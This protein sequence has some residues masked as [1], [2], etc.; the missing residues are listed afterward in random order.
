[1]ETSSQ[2]LSPAMSPIPRAASQGFSFPLPDL[3]EFPPDIVPNICNIEIP[4]DQRFPMSDYSELPPFSQL[5]QDAF[6]DPSHMRKYRLM[7]PGGIDKQAQL[8]CKYRILLEKRLADLTETV[9]E[10]FKENQ[11][12]YVIFEERYNAKM[13]LLK[14]RCW[15]DLL[16][17]MIQ[18]FDD[19]ASECDDWNSSQEAC[20]EVSQAMLDLHEAANKILDEGTEPVLKFSDFHKTFPPCFIQ[21]FENSIYWN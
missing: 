7:H 9:I 4:L 6:K 20:E 18:D 17:Q 13:Y 3:C 5:L 21:S 19:L 14:C 11:T 16:E 1:M 8:E 2:Q 10:G 12:D 15:V